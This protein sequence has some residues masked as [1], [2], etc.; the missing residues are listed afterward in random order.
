MFDSREYDRSPNIYSPEGRL[1]QL[2][3]SIEAVKLG[4]TVIGI[5]TPEGVILAAEKRIPSPLMHHDSINKISEIDH[6]IG[7]VVAGLMPDSRSL[8][9]HA[10]MQAQLHRF[11]YAEPIRVEAC[12]LAICDLS[13]GFG[14]NKAG[15]RMSRPYG[16]SMLVAGVDEE[17]PS[18][19]QTEPSGTYYNYLT[20]AVGAGAEGAMSILQGADPDAEADLLY[21]SGMSL[22][23]ASVLA[24]RVLKEVMEEKLTATNVE[25]AAVRA[26][27]EC[28][29]G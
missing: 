23:A 21:H 22:E 17:G 6:H 4:S 26:G 16:V 29:V 5:Q 13:L 14:E 9:D 20:K 19:W 18:L 11:N 1:L 7:C 25:M 10:R 27:P 28:G 3:Y 15:K 8:V 2:E 12:T 24:V